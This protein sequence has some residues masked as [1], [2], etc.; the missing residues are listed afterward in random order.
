VEL[1]MNLRALPLCL[2]VAAI[3]CAPQAQELA[4]Q[5]APDETRAPF[6]TFD[7][8]APEELHGALVAND[9][10]H[11]DCVPPAGGDMFRLGFAHAD[12]RMTLT[13]PRGLNEAGETA[14]PLDGGTVALFVQG[15]NGWC[16][17]WAG[18]VTFTRDLP[19]WMVTIDARCRDAAVDPVIASFSGHDSR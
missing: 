19:S 14:I 8:S 6:C 1:D 18:D 16:R 7:V 5:A 13:I 9:V 4:Y 3:G 11:L 2:L 12:W 10:A 15:A 17:D